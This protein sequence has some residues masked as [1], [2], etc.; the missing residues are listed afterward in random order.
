MATV[1]EGNKAAL[2]MAVERNDA[3][4]RAWQR[5]GGVSPVASLEQALV[6]L[7]LCMVGDLSRGVSGIAPHDAVSFTTLVGA[8]EK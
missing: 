8:E 5:D 3:V 2:A 6:H 4:A 1:R 7:S